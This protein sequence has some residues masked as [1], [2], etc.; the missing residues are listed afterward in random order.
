MVSPWSSPLPLGEYTPCK[1]VV[2]FHSRRWIPIMFYSLVDAIA[3]C[4]EA[5]PEGKELFVFPPG[6]NPCEFQD[7]LNSTVLH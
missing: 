4:Y 3:L 5:I 1:V 7:S 6:L 2:Y